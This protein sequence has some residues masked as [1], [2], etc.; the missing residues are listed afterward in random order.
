MGTRADFY[1][2]KNKNL[3]YL[4]SI[5]W[6]GYPICNNKLNTDL[7]SIIVAKKEDTYKNE[8]LKLITKRE[9]GSLPERD[10]W[11][12]P[13]DDSNTTDYSYIFTNNKVMCSCF[14]SKLYNP[15]EELNNTFEPKGECEFNFPNM[16]NIQRVA[17]NEKSGLLIIKV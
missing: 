10:G 6:D 2:E 4:G 7:K 13:W 17:L 14:G 8:V 12:W 15:R 5:A 1:I 11:P 3:T 16:K 9:D